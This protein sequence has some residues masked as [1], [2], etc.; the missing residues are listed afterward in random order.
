[1][2]LSF[3]K[4]L[5]AAVNGAAVGWGMDLA[6]AC[7]I[8]IASDRARFG[9]VY[10]LRGLIPDIAGF[11]I[12]PLIVGLSKAYELLLTGDVI[13][14]Q[15]AERIGLVSKVVP[16]DDL[17]SV[18]KEMAGK[19]AKMP[20]IATRMTK[21]AMRKG[22]NY[23]LG[24]LGEYHSHALRVLFATEDFREGSTSVLERRQ[25]VFKGR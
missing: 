14:A 23:S 11:Y 7:D 1:M 9:E 6:L 2:L 15:E 13:D 4:P 12:L 5:I 3:E 16:H 21:E 8:R 20:P 18:T 19:I 25:P 17:L 24:V 10:I 22:M